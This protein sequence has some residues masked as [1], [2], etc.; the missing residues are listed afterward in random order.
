M[1]KMVAASP[2]AFR[3]SCREGRHISHTS[4]VLPGFLQANLLILPKEEAEDFADLCYRNPVPCPLLATTIGDPRISSDDTLL[5]PGTFDIRTDFPKYNIYEKGHLVDQKTN[6]N[7]EWAPGYVGFLIGC[8][9]SF[10]R[11]LCQAKLTPK[12]VTLGKN[13]SMFKTTKMLNPAG[14]FTNCPY[15]VSMRPFKPQDIPAIRAITRKFRRTHGEP[16]D[17]GFDGAQRLGI[18]NLSR[19]DYGDFVE[20]CEDEVPVF[21]ACGVTP[22][23]A[24]ETVGHLIEGPVIGHT[25]GHM[26][27]C[28]LTDEELVNKK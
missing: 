12:N 3:E 6:C 23:L 5:K 8:S 1:T 4:G 27:L 28:D 2:E 11:A 16:I 9:Y 14:I 25:P 18:K 19:P 15:V 20:I 22:Q 24:I 17:W 7:D 21:W 26:L 10:E 13:V